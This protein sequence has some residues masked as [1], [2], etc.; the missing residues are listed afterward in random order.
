MQKKTED[1]EDRGDIRDASKVGDI[2]DKGDA[3]NNDT[4]RTKNRAVDKRD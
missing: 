1:K 3:G 4:P 2:R